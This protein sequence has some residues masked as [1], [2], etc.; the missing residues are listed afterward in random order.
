M[1]QVIK[2]AILPF[3]V[4]TL[5]SSACKPGATANPVIIATT[6]LTSAPALSP[7]SI[8]TLMPASTSTLTPTSTE[9]EVTLQPCEL[10]RLTHGDI[11]YSITFSPDGKWLA[12]ACCDYS[13]SV[14]DAA[15]GQK[16][17]S[18]SH[19]DDV[20]AIAFSPDSKWLATA[21][22]DKT[23]RV[24]DVSCLA[25]TYLPDTSGARE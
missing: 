12:T 2:V 3:L 17:A 25:E 18:L 19:E 11:V 1:N 23:A 16:L 8:P 21:S 10:Y 15:T 24:W 14:W 20:E 22:D 13:V 5:L 7:T 6:T 4:L 9:S